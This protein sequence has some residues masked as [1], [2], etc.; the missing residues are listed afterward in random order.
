MA[1]TQFTK[2]PDSVLDYAVDWQDV[3]EDGESILSSS[4]T[5]ED[6]GNADDLK[7]HSKGTAVDSGKVLIWLED[8]VAGETY[9]VT[10]AI[11]TSDDRQYDR[12]FRIRVVNM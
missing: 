12:T 1:L 6:L 2:D 3:L 10:N 9:E 4:W 8:G 11:S 7:E 5:V